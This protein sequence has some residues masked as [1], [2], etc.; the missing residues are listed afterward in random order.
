M[1]NIM[2]FRSK[3]IADFKKIQKRHEAQIRHLMRIV[4]FPYKWVVFSPLLVLLTTVFGVCIVVTSFFCPPRFTNR[5]GALWGFLCAKLVPMSVAVEGRQHIDEHQSYVVVANHLSHLDIFALYGWLG[6]DF[7]WVVKM[8]LRKVPVLGVA[9]EKMGHV[10]I[11]RSNTN[12]AL[13]SINAAAEK[14]R[15]GTS[16]L[17]FPE[18]TRSM[19]GE[20]QDFKKGA[21]RMAA[22][23][24][25][26]ILP[27]S[28]IGTHE[29]L[30]PKTRDLFPGK[31]RIVIHPPIAIYPGQD[32]EAFMNQVHTIIEKGLKAD[33]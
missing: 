1:E 6:I 21:F 20:L 3:L 15:N 17:F 32:I 4:Y 31:A 24:N 22:D 2:Q 27:I 10:Y 7:R 11:D 19:S 18:G 12:R 9:G 23:L 5:F 8:E 30:P 14:I 13:Q 26:P 29:I 28:I 33:S 16:I 25:L